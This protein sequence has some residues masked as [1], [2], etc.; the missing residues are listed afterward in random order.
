ML[1]WLPSVLVPFVEQLPS[2]LRANKTRQLLRD[3]AGFVF[4]AAVSQPG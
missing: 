2:G 3:L 4:W 1:C